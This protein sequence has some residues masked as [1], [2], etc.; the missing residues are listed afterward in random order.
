MSSAQEFCVAA[1]QRLAKWRSVFAG[2]QLGTRADTDPECRAVRDQT[3]ARLLLRAEVSAIVALLVAKKFVTQDELQLAVGEEAEA[4][5][6]IL[7]RKFPGFKACDA[8]MRIDLAE[9]AETMKGWR[10]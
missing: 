3:E 8:G 1:C 10:P 7:E 4:L 6:A 2:W 5:C 9:A